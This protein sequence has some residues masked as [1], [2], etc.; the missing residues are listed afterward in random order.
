MPRACGESL[1]FM[2]EAE[3]EEYVD[4]SDDA[5]YDFCDACRELADVKFIMAACGTVLGAARIP[6]LLLATSVAGLVLMAVMLTAGLASG[7]RLRHLFRSLCD[8]RYDPWKSPGRAEAANEKIRGRE[9]DHAHG[10]RI[11]HADSAVSDS[12]TDSAVADLAREVPDQLR[13]LFGG[14]GR[15]RLSAGGSG[16]G[17]IRGRRLNIRIIHDILFRCRKIYD[18]ALRNAAII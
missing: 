15:D 12:R 4:D 18:P 3:F 5:V 13:R 9:R 14:A 11:D 1:P 17:G 6:L 8:W 10:I 16:D 2:M 7:S